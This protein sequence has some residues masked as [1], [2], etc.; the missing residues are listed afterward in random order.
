MNRSRKEI[1]ES[2]KVIAVIGCSADPYRTSHHIA[3]Y[4]KNEGY[5]II[6]V[7]PEYEEV[8]GEKCYNSITDIS[9]EI[10]IDVVD[11]FRNA[12]YTADMVDT[13]IERVKK[14]G[15][16]P[17][18]WTQLGVSS[19]GA[20]AKAADAGLQYIEERCMMVD[21]QRELGVKN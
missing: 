7:N 13:V 12:R 8:L 18:V 5:R 4:L 16:K 14:T 6:P 17:V 3:K 1:L 15:H 2:A 9:G 10:Q 21:H 19:P 11:I 20:K